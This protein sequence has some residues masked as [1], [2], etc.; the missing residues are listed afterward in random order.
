MAA[1]TVSIFGLPMSV[2]GGVANIGR[3]TLINQ[4]MNRQIEAMNETGNRKIT[5][6]RWREGQPPEK[7]TGEFVGWDGK[8]LIMR[9]E[10]K[11]IALPS[12]EWARPP[13]A[14]AFWE[15]INDIFAK[16]PEGIVRQ[17][18]DE[19]LKKLPTSEIPKA[20]K[21]LWS[22]MDNLIKLYNETKSEEEVRR[23]I[24]EI[25]TTKPGE[26]QP[27]L[28]F[29]IPEEAAIPEQEE[30]KPEVK[31][32]PEPEVKPEPGPEP[33]VKPEPELEPEVKPEIITKEQTVELPEPLVRVVE[34]ILGVKLTQ[35]ITTTQLKEVNEELKKNAILVKIKL[36]TAK[37]QKVP[38]R[39]V[40]ISDNG[41]VIE[42]GIVA[43]AS[44]GKTNAGKTKFLKSWAIENINLVSP[45]KIVPRETS[46]EVKPPPE[47]QEKTIPPPPDDKELITRIREKAEAAGMP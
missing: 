32:E 39:L 33:E 29:S 35:P 8:K 7:I 28:P 40:E 13:E 37:P 31:P 14:D 36:Q 1:L 9:V 47:P 5:A 21:Q 19:A 24:D 42:E 46:E 3:Y 41:I 16:S 23:R 11:E 6:W 20:N 18:A 4:A 12:E 10:G 15:K 25:I 43:G 30:V 26:Q 38:V 27:Q 17:L 2:S 45:P 22:A 44:A 34:G